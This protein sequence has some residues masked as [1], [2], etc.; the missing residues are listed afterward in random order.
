MVD[1]AGA[2]S[3]GVAKELVIHANGALTAPERRDP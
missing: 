2:A 3:L 1:S